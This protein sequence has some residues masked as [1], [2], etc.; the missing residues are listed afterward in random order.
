MTTVSKVTVRN[1]S[2][3]ERKNR[4]VIY[5]SIQ[6]ETII[7]NIVERKCRPHT[8]YRKM[9]PQAIEIL[10]AQ[11]FI[12]EDVKAEDVKLS[13]SQYAGC[14]CPCSPGF[15]V[16]SHHLHRKDVWMTIG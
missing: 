6:G 4:G 13:W 12:N 10:K 11:G 1:R 3:R 14:S 7:Q 5:V 15:I 8:E 16:T 2:H 9:M